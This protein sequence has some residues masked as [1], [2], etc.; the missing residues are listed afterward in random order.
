MR[1]GGLVALLILTTGCARHEP[2]RSAPLV[3]A[4]AVPRT[5][6]EEALAL[7]LS[8]APPNSRGAREVTE[9]QASARASPASS[10]AW[11]RLGHAWMRHARAACDPGAHLAA[12]ACVQLA[13]ALAPEDPAIG[14]LDAMVLLDMHRFRDA[15]DAASAVLAVDNRQLDALAVLSDASVELGDIDAAADAVQ[16]MVDARPG[17]PSYSR[18][19]YLRWL[20]GDVDGAEEGMQLAASAGDARD[21]DPL[22][23]ILVQWATLRWNVGD[24]DGAAMRADEALALVADHPAALL[25][26]ARI[27]LAHSRPDDAVRLVERAEVLAP[28]A[29]TAWLLGDAREAAGDPAGA[30]L[31][32]ETLRRR[33]R[34]D[35]RTLASFDATKGVDTA[36]ALRLIEGELQTRAGTATEDVHGWLL[37]R[38][39]RFDEALAAS[40][41]AI[42]WGTKEPTLLYHAGAIRIA[43]GQIAEGVALV[44]EALRL[45][46]HFDPTGATEAAR[47][48]ERVAA[49]SDSQAPSPS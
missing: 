47:L 34:D 46:P 21:P 35:A 40:N 6:S 41:R 19:A 2:S 12:A 13:R 38:G 44:R 43:R 36:D 39:G 28:L 24:L 3:P 4:D 1:L 29:E 25:L 48:I 20:L 37:Y 14:A 5:T 18:V 49:P 30:A 23:W 16:T 33:G 27:A 22:A 9:L 31:A 10:V 26:K 42:H 8:S 17:L 7:A 45:N 32:F 11:L 15:R